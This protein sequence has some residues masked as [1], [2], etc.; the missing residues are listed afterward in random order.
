MGGQPA[1][2]NNNN[3]AQQ[4][5]QQQQTPRNTYPGMRASAP[6]Q[7]AAPVSL[8]TPPPRTGS[9]A[10][11]SHMT[12]SA[13]PSTSTTTTTTYP[14]GS[15]NN[16]VV[17]GSQVEAGA[18]AP[19][20][21]TAVSSENTTTR[22]GAYLVSRTTT[23]PAQVYRVTV[24]AGVRPGA[25][26]TVHAGPRRVRVRCP[27]TSSPGQSLQIT[28][29]PEPITHHL[30]LKMSPLTA[31]EPG[32]DGGGA[33]PMT[34]EVH[35]VNQQAAMA[36]GTAQTFLVTIPP[37]IYPGM[38]FTVNV[39]GGQRFMVTCPETA[40]PNMKVRIVPP[41]TR[42]EPEA[43]PKT[44]VFEVAVPAGV[45]PGQPFALVANGQ[46]VLV[47]CPPTVSAGQKIRFQLPVSQIAGSIKLAYESQG[48]W[49][50]T[51]RVTDLK[52]QWIRLEGSDN[53]TPTEDSVRNID[54]DGMQSF[55]FTKSAYVRQLTFLE[56]NDARMR[57]GKVELVPAD[58]AVVDSR[59]VVHNRTLLSYADIAEVQGK[60]LEE[61][62]A[63]FE[64]ICTQLTSAWEDGH[65]KL[66]VRRK[67]LLLD[68]VD[69]VMSLGRDDLR[70][71][72][73]IEFLGEPAIDAGGVARE[74]FQ[75]VTEQIFDADSGLWLSSAN[76]QMC[77]T[78]NPSSGKLWPPKK[79]TRR[80][81]TRIMFDKPSHKLC[82]FIL[83]FV[84]FIICSHVLP[85]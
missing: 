54:V 13:P 15:S 36:G 59:L 11:R 21:A 25:E 18:R 58:Q 32:G 83:V 37:N 53:D 27:P 14:S 19:P 81:S 30:S 33:V 70:K 52:F 6:P 26:F 24:P 23:G 69:A 10:L 51:I 22:P 64:N 44:Q 71:R 65:I 48:G 8:P 31:G 77:C 79:R 3:N 84:I 60:P 17:R 50:R 61:K 34:P 80:R 66:V 1:R 43:A 82:F 41:A 42:E 35:S 46:R 57:T 9:M 40:G 45:Q 63:W 62:T 39:A 76:N 56:G 55:D 5:Q 7:G 28:L 78:I 29:P 12:A 74:W 73:R 85:G 38:Q 72:W 20:P 2:N 49:S 16:T 47:T 4:Q 67:H 75:L 68:S